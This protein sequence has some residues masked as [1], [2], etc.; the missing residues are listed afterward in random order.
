[1]NPSNQHKIRETGASTL[2]SAEHAEIGG[3]KPAEV[4]DA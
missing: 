1:M 2:G 3:G 4:C